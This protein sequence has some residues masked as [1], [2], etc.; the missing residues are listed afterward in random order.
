MWGGQECV[1]PKREKGW[2][3][4]MKERPDTEQ[5]GGGGDGESSGMTNRIK[6][7]ILK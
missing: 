4:V 5:V 7:A 1:L 6:E 3:G 2:N